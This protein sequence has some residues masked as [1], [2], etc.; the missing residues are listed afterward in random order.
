M[1]TGR[2]DLH[3][4]LNMVSLMQ[5]MNLNGFDV[6]SRISLASG[7]SALVSQVTLIYRA[8]LAHLQH[9]P[10]SAEVLHQQQMEQEHTFLNNVDIYSATRSA[11]SSSYGRPRAP[12]TSSAG[13]SAMQAAKMQFGSSGKGVAISGEHS[14]RSFS[15][16]QNELPPVADHQRADDYEN[17]SIAGKSIAMA[18]NFVGEMLK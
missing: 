16:M 3:N 6:L 12:S 13:S 15:R 2:F 1:S 11:R 18:L 5:I 14:Q 17:D 7:E 9:T 10:I 4:S 8:L